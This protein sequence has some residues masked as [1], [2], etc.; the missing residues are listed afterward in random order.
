MLFRLSARIP[1]V[2]FSETTIARMQNIMMVS[3]WPSLQ[4]YAN[5]Y[6]L[7]PITSYSNKTP[8]R[9]LLELSL[10]LR[11]TLDYPLSNKGGICVSPP[12][13]YPPLLVCHCC[14]IPSRQ[15][16]DE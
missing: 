7:G 4:H 15:L 1:S 12:S 13:V 5:C 14:L 6:S 9:V 16:Q 2:S 3:H 11:S 8:R 10:A